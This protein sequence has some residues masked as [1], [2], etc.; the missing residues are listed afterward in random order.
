MPVPV[1]VSNPNGK[2]SQTHIHKSLPTGKRDLFANLG[3]HSVEAGLA[4]QQ[5][6]QAEQARNARRANAGA[7][8]NGNVSASCEHSVECSGLEFRYIGED[9]MPL[10][11]DRSLSLHSSTRH[12][13]P[14]CVR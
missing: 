9:G 2:G 1:T 6:T 14:D 3:V 12:A 13:P 11:G 7:G 10:P 4:G 5:A 8:E